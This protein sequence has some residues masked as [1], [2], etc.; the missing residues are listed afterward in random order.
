MKYASL[1]EKIA[2]EKKERLERYRYFEEV[3]YKAVTAGNKA[4]ETVVPPTMIVSQHANQ[5]DDCS[6]IVNHWLKKS[7]EWAEPEGPCGFAE[8]RLPKGNTSFA[9]WAKK[10]AGFRKHC[11]GGLFHWVSAFGQSMVRKEAFA[12]SAV[13]V[14]V[15][16]GIDAYAYSRMD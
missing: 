12:R 4:A 6:P 16:N 1:R 10:N 13:G 7:L 2:A 3:W 14:L 11:H 5:L 15:D 9:H 8:I